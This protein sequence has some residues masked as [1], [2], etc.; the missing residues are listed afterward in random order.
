MT[1]KSTKKALLLSLL[2][3]MVCVSMLIGTTFAWFTDSVTSGRNTIQSGNLDVE[4]YFAAKA[5]AA[6]SE[7][8]K[9][10]GRTDIFGYNNWEPG[11]TKVVYFKIV[12][13]GSLALK[14]QLTADVY[15]EKQGTNK[16]GV[17]FSLSDYLYSE[18]VAADAT[19]ESILASTTGVKVKDTLAVKDVGYLEKGKSEIIGFAI[20]MPITADNVANH[21][22]DAPMIDLGINLLA[23]QKMSEGDSFGNDYDKN[24]EYAAVVYDAAGL[25]NALT[26]G[27]KV[28]VMS[29]I[30]LD[31][32]ITVPAGVT[33]LLDLGDN[34]ITG[35]TSVIENKGTLVL[36]GN[37]TIDVSGATEYA[38]PVVNRGTLTVNDGVYVGASAMPSYGFANYGTMTINNATVDGG[39]GGV[40]S[41]ENSETVINDGT[42]SHRDDPGAH[43]VYAKSGAKVTINGGDFLG[44][45]QSN[46]FWQYVVYAV[47]T[48]D[49][50]INGGN[51][52]A[53]THANGTTRLMFNAGAPISVLGG[54]F[55]MEPAAYIADGHTAT[56]NGDGTWTVERE[57][58]S[59]TPAGTDKV[60]N[61]S[62]L[63][64][65]INA[66]TESS[67]IALDAGEYKM[68]SVGGNKEV[69]IVGTKDTVIDMTLGAYMDQSTV[70]FEGV[71]IKGSRGKANGNGSDDAAFYTP[72]VTYTDCTF[73]GP[74]AVGRDGAKF[75]R[76]TFNNLGND[77]VW[78][79]ACDTVFDSCTF[80]SD[81]KALLLY[82]H[83]TD[84]GDEMTT[85]V[86]KNCVFNA[87]QKA[88][89]GA[90]TNQQCAAIEIQ[91]YGCGFNL[92]TSGNTYDSDFSGEWRIKTYNTRSPLYTITINGT[93][94]TTTALDGK[95]MT[96]TGGIATFN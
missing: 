43:I 86:V 17:K 94:Y 20:W 40:W 15:S 33:A 64:D 48:A 62:A 77:Y 39:F 18:V 59:V 83:G 54:T 8:Q 28:A 11:Y 78:N 91:N 79:M 58:I 61:G 49:V 24:A 47:T 36:N 7:W 37:G 84:S 60:A 44:H 89:A 51:F 3:L 46:N 27:G 76:C 92:T 71:T 13:N 34:K 67:Y 55:D 32:T 50:K 22:G 5:D 2:S 96:V 63:A 69:T 9:V 72:N 25:A 65:V 56:D 74:F 31:E 1:N 90:V 21:N 23:T 82:A 73:E 38:V 57:Y 88:Y 81:G 95:L 87:T 12:N 4:L 35:N 70:A 45:V 93:E 16:E 30:A 68:P 26:L 42:F 52:V 41:M 10:D 6:D 19:R 85:V 75:I 29:D 14:Y 66:T 53:Y 80:N